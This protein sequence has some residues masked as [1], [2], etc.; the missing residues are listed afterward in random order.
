MMSN[1]KTYMLN[2]SLLDDVEVD[3]VEDVEESSSESKYFR[4]MILFDRGDD[5]LNN[6]RE[7]LTHALSIVL[8]KHKNGRYVKNYSIDIDKDS[9]GS[10]DAHCNIQ[11]LTEYNDI[12]MF[13]M[14]LAD[15]CAVFELNN[16]IAKNAEIRVYIDETKNWSFDVKMLT[17]SVNSKITCK[18]YEFRFFTSFYLDLFGVF[19]YS[20]ILCSFVKCVLQ[21]GLMLPMDEDKT[22]YVIYVGNFSK[23]FL[24]V[25][26]NRGNFVF[27]KECTHSVFLEMSKQFSPEGY[28]LFHIDDDTYNFFDKNGKFLSNDNFNDYCNCRSFSEGFAAVQRYTDKKWNFVDVN[29]KELCD[30][31]YDNV[32]DFK[33]GVAIVTN[34]L[35]QNI[36]GPDGKTR[37]SDW[38][39]SIKY[40]RDTNYLK[41]ENESKYKDVI[42]L[43]GNLISKKKNRRFADI[44]DFNIN[45]YFVV[46]SNDEI[47]KRLLKYD[48]TILL[49]KGY[50]A[51]TGYPDTGVLAVKIETDTESWNFI[52]INTENKLYSYNFIS[53]LAK[54]I[55]GEKYDN[56]RFYF[57][58]KKIDKTLYRNVVTENGILLFDNDEWPDYVKYMGNGLFWVE[59]G[60]KDCSIR[61]IDG[62]VVKSNIKEYDF[63]NEFVDGYAIVTKYINGDNQYNFIDSSGN[64]CYPSEWFK[65]MKYKSGFFKVVNFINEE[66]IISVDGVKM[67]K[68]NVRDKKFIK[69]WEVIEDGKVVLVRRL[70]N[71]CNIFDKDG[72]KWFKTWTKDSIEV[73]SDGTVRVG[74]NCILDCNGE[75]VVNI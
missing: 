42:D 26:D 39:R 64:V 36:I 40:F 25:F 62:T 33:N 30:K 23:A 32:A 46:S 21:Y 16:S 41:V 52:E 14:F 7:L 73:K 5:E 57:V 60:N 71:F 61:K 29:G 75:V 31:W 12:D 65:D 22:R 15:V 69:N 2:E 43:N 54:D 53:C 37:C 9:Y 67:I 6:V 68:W 70:N 45:G 38:Y 20:D 28:I 17:Q 51:I 34:L 11:V 66:N 13:N 19:D 72:K 48:G 55:Y 74:L 63:V 59:Y 44:E 3:E 18:C 27:C 47:K 4:F 24:Y 10:L 1:Y 8:D 56:V 50:D 58:S 49:N 35:K